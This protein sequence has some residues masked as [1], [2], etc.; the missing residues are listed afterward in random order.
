M[1]DELLRKDENFVIGIVGGM[2][3]YATV[4]FFRRVIDAF[5][6]EKEWDRPRVI[7]DNYCTMPSRVRAVLY[8]E[9]REELVTQLTSAVAGMMNA[10]V[11]R[12]VFACNTSHIF[13]PDVISR[14]PECEPCVIHIIE[15][16]SRRMA[17]EGIPSAGLVA[18]EGTIDTGIY[19]SIFARHEIRI[20]APGRDDFGKLR[21]FIEAVK[22]QS[23]RDGLLEEF[24]SFLDGFEDDAVILGCTELPILYSRCRE[25]GLESSKRVFDP[26]Q[27]A[28]DTL[29][30]AYK[31]V[32]A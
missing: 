1:N 25:K 10:G 19:E 21:E 18:T 4:D 27:A 16:C 14:I 29:V 22:Q 17:E 3:S 24:V 15:E 13:V 32:E 28:I 6:A 9:R 20:N 7:V 11:D 23:I 8:G 26:L 2:G 5:P 12:I 30:K 31:E